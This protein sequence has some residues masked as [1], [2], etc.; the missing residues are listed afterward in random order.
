MNQIT[1]KYGLE[2]AIPTLAN[3]PNVTFPMF[4]ADETATLDDENADLIKNLM[5]TPLLLVDI[6]VYAVG[7]GLAGLGILAGIF[8][9][10]R[11]SLKSA[12]PS[13]VEKVYQ[14]NI[15]SHGNVSFK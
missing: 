10:I 2:L 7:F 14:Q 4:W 9:K 1:E 6:F 3:V 12:E 5:V 8:L 11:F 15:I 13:Y